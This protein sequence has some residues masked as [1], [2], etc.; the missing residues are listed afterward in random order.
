[1]YRLF[2]GV[3]ELGI[4]DAQ[5]S[6][7]G[8]IWRTEKHSGCQ[9]KGER[10]MAKPPEHRKDDLGIIEDCVDQAAGKEQLPVPAN[11]NVMPDEEVMKLLSQ[12]PAIGWGY[13]IVDR[14][15]TLLPPDDWTN[16]AWFAEA[17]K[18][19]STAR[20]AHPKRSRTSTRPK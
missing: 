3:W 8:Q 9:E 19:R 2:L 13:T 18:V 7:T 12:L 6:P 5:E 11:D 14:T 20:T 1:M 17:R 4:P 16:A 10:G 15:I